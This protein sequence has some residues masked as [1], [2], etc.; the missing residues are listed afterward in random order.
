MRGQAVRG[1]AVAARPHPTCWPWHGALGDLVA[2]VTEASG[3]GSSILCAR[4]LWQQGTVCQP[5]HA[6]L[7]QFLCSAGHWA[8]PQMQL[9]SQPH[10]LACFLLGVDVR[11]CLAWPF[12]P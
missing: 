7:Q 1:L 6:P 5:H 10:P 2:A 11:S 3:A 9:H 12:P 8:P 4:E